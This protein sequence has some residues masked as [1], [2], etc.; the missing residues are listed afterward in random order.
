MS[1]DSAAEIAAKI[2][3]EIITLDPVK[4]DTGTGT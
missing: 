4:Q 3:K 1:A 2:K